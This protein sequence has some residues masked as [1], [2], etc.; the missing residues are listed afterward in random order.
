VDRQALAEQFA[1]GY[2]IVEHPDGEREKFFVPLSGSLTLGRVRGGVMLKDMSISRA[3][4]RITS[5]STSVLLEHL[6][7][8]IP[9]TL[10]NAESPVQKCE[11][12][13]GDLVKIGKTRIRFHTLESAL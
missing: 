6:G 5:V 2:L 8:R 10:N 12:H 4:A 7:S 9:I 11:L 13:D 3:A 1:D